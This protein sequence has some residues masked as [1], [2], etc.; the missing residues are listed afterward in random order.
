MPVVVRAREYYLY[1]RFGKRYV[2]FFQNH[3]RAILGHR[4]EGVQRALKSTISRGLVAEYPSVYQ[5]RLEKILAQLLPDFPYVRIYPRQ[6]SVA[7]FLKRR[8]GTDE[9]ADPATGVMPQGCGASYWRPF[10]GD[11]GADTVLLFPILPFPGSFIP[12]IVCAGDEALANE[13][14]PSSPASPLLLDLLVK[15][16]S[17]LLRMYESEEAV[18]SRAM[19]N[20]LEGLFGRPRGPYLLT[21]L[22]ED[23]YRKLFHEAL[24]AGVVLPPGP[25]IPM[26]FPARYNDGDVAEFRRIAA[27]YC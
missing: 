5:G 3:G 11:G 7:E 21:G 26:I 17:A 9:V 8:F 23:R 24:E 20:P 12:E 22:P 10:L 4:P 6:G 15:S 25:G 2:D 27:R 13:L 1:D 18:A 19:G 16:V 14:P